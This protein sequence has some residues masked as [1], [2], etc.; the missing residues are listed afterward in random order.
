MKF[1]IY[2]NEDESIRLKLIRDDGGK[3]TDVCIVDKDGDMEQA[4][5]AFKDNGSV[6]LYNHL[7]AECGLKLDCG[8]HL[9]FKKET[10][11]CEDD[12]EC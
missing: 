10:E 12:C 8:G 1:T 5:I 9:K 7:N 6:M 2:E 4:L 11:S 3:C